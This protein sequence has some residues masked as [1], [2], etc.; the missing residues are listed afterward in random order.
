MRFA[1][2]ELADFNRLAA[3]PGSEE[4]S[5]ELVDSV[6]EAAGQ[7][8]SEVLFPSAPRRA[9][10]PPIASSAKAAGQHCIATPNTAARACPKPSACCSRK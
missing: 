1:L 7:I 6:L 5:P 10:P 9:S 3:L 4:L 2:Y 8:C